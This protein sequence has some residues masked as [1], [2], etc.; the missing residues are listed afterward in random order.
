MPSMVCGEGTTHVSDL[1]MYTEATEQSIG[2]LCQPPSSQHQTNDGHCQANAESPGASTKANVDPNNTRCV[3]LD[4]PMASFQ[5]SPG[6]MFQSIHESTAPDKMMRAIVE[7]DDF[8]WGVDEQTRGMGATSREPAM[9][10]PLRKV[11]VMKDV[12]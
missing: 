3:S 5:E 6:S 8:A 1:T 7:M 12:K 10:E 11:S 4:Q 9:E 2:S